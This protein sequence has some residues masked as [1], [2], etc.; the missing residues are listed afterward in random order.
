MS[1]PIHPRRH[2][3]VAVLLLVGLWLPPISIGP[4][5]ATAISADPDEAESPLPQPATPR[6]AVTLE[7]G[8]TD[9]PVGRGVTLTARADRSETAR[10]PRSEDQSFVIAIRREAGHLGSGLE[11]TCKSRAVCTVEVRADQPSARRFA[12]ALYRCGPQGICV[13]EEDATESDKVDVTWR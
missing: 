12:A 3:F 10:A 4:S 8:A 6:R 1:W 9:A 7:A 13:L 2:L 11:A 5:P